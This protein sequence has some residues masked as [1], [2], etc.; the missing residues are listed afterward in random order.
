MSKTGLLDLQPQVQILGVCIPARGTGAQLSPADSILQ[1]TVLS[2]E[3]GVSFTPGLRNKRTN[4][5]PSSISS[6]SPSSS[7]HCLLPCSCCRHP[8]TQQ[9]GCEKRLCAGALVLP[10]L[11]SILC[12]TNPTVLDLLLACS[13]YDSPQNLNRSEIWASLQIIN[14]S[15]GQ[16][17][18]ENAFKGSVGIIHRETTLPVGC[19]EPLAGRLLCPAMEAM[20]PLIYSRW[21][22]RKLYTWPVPCKNIC[23]AA[24]DGICCHSGHQ[25]VVSG[26]RK[27][28][29]SPYRTS[30]LLCPEVF[31]WLGV[32]PL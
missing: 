32:P 27:R 11:S 26:A 17:R 19:G 29:L 14:Y 31:F 28:L 16:G 21:E 7:T 10:L 24:A 4:V 2:L 1:R 23:D 3:A 5:L 12:Q 25:Q 13:W 6:P 30:G 18:G 15:S 22:S 9:E 8:G 20:N